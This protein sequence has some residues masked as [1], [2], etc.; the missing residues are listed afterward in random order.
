MR[1]PS[2]RMPL[3]VAWLLIAL[4][5]CGLEAPRFEPTQATAAILGGTPSDAKDDAIVALRITRDDG[6]R[7]LCSGVV[8]GPRLVLTAAHCVAPEVVGR[9]ATFALFV[10]DDLAS[11]LT[12]ELE[13]E[14]VDFDPDFDLGLIGRGHDIGVVI[15]KE[16]LF[17]TPVAFDKAPPL[18]EVQSVRIV[19][20]GITAEEVADS[21]GL[22]RQAEVALAGFDALFLTLG[23]GAQP[24]SGDSGGAVFA[25]VDGIEKLVGIVSF[26]EDSCAPGAKVT[27]LSS[28]QPYLRQQ[29][30]AAEAGDAS[31]GSC[32]MTST[33]LS[34]APLFSMVLLALLALRV[35]RLSRAA[36]A[37]K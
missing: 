10:G 27:N 32:Q 23:E 21:G 16:P 36:L 31:G 25:S 34:D 30:A 20:Y 33:R 24:C 5:S 1:P 35:R 28:Y 8:I 26:T 12:V 7:G 6:A 17:V 37:P 29:L 11:E 18:E 2:R 3:Q 22:R 9:N 13:V 15:T 4:A 19:G 14:R